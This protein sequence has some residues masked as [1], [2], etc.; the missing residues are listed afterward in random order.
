[1]PSIR[2]ERPQSSTV[3]SGSMAGSRERSWRAGSSAS[4]APGCGCSE[5]AVRCGTAPCSQGLRARVA[6]G[7][8]ANRDDRNSRPGEAPRPLAAGPS[9]AGA[10]RRDRAGRARSL[11]QPRPAAG[12]DADRLAAAP[13]DDRAVPLDE[14]QLRGDGRGATGAAGPRARRGVA[15]LAG[16]H[17]GAGAQP[18]RDRARPAGLRRQPDAEVDDQHPQLRVDGARLHRGAG[19]GAGAGGRQLDGRVRRGGD[20]DPRRAGGH[21]GRARVVSGRVTCPDV[22]GAHGDG[23][24]DGHRRWRR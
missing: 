18:P 7:Y 3:R 4:F 14:G 8:V 5:S 24:A 2:S 20:V 16:E 23:R 1:M 12:V 9:L 22:Q 13:A 19:D 6:R 15:E 17:P 21:E 10:P 11:R